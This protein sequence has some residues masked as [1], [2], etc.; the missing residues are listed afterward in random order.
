MAWFRC[1]ASFRGN[2]DNGEGGGSVG[3]PEMIFAWE[4]GALCISELGQQRDAVGSAFAQR[5]T[6]QNSSN[7]TSAPAQ[8]AACT[9]FFVCETSWIRL[10]RILRM[11]EWCLLPRKRSRISRRR[12]YVLRT[13]D[14]SRR[15]ALTFD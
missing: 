3:I 8:G 10:I 4:S 14:R 13:R 5:F 2:G 9:T 11:C 1:S 15:R 12:F 6:L 7:E